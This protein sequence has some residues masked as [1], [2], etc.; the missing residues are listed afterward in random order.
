[1]RPLFSIWTA[2]VLTVFWSSTRPVYFSLESS[3]SIASLFHLGLPVGGRNT[4]L[5]QPGSN[6]PQTVTSKI[7]FNFVPKL[8]AVIASSSYGTGSGFGLLWVGQ[9][10]GLALTCSGRTLSWS[11]NGSDGAVLEP[12]N[13]LNIGGTKYCYAAMG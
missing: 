13:Q 7:S 1:M 3:L 4:L 12:K 11:Y 8:V 5:F 2:P 6:F 9:M 10:G